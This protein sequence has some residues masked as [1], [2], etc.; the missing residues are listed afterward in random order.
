MACKK[1]VTL[2]KEGTISWRQENP[3]ERPD[4]F[5]TILSGADL[6]EANLSRFPVCL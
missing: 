3:D 1:A 4:L 5:E 2:I 6:S